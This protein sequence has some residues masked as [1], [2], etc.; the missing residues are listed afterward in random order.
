MA[1]LLHRAAI[2]I[3]CFQTCW[4]MPT[5]CRPTTH[6]PLQLLLLSISKVQYSKTKRIRLW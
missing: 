5:Y 6:W 1:P 4:T 3:N 2:M